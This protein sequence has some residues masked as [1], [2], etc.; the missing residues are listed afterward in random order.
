MSDNRSTLL[1]L[2]QIIVTSLNLEGI[3][4]EAIDDHMP[5]KSDG[6]GLDSVDVLE[7]IVHIE[8]EFGVRIL[9]GEVDQRI[10]TSVA[11]LVGFLD[12]R[13]DSPAAPPP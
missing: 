3:A 12:S 13:R 6:L 9:N 8:K 7:L 2:K 4:P 11:S 1:R 10:F 5:L